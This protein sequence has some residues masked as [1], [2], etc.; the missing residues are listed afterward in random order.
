[1]SQGSEHRRIASS[2]Y[3]KCAA[4]VRRSR[5]IPAFLNA[6]LFSIAGLSAFLLRFD[7]HVPPDYR[8][9]LVIGVAIWV[10]VKSVVFARGR[11]SYTNWRH[12]SG[13]DTLAI[14]GY[15]LSGS[16]IAIP[17]IWL[18]VPPGFPRSLY[19]L[20]LIL[21]THFGLTVYV[22]ARLA[23]EHQKPRDGRK[24]E[25]IFIYGAGSS[26]ATLAREIRT[27]PELRYQVCGFL[28]DDPVKQHTM[29]QRIQVLGTGADLAK[30]ARRYSIS[31]VLIAVPSGTTDEMTR[32]L[33]HCRDAQVPCKTV[34]PISRLIGHTRL[35]SQ[36]RDVAVEDLLGRN[37][38]RLA[39][40]EIRGKI[41]GHTV[42]VTGA[43]GSI[44]SELCRQLARFQPAAIIG[45]D[46]SET[47]LF[48]VQ[49]EMRQS[50]PEVP[51]IAEIGSI[52]NPGRLRHVLDRL[53]P[54]VL[55]HAA[56]Y[57]HVPLMEASIFEAV[58][59]NV[60]GTYSVARAAAE[61]GV[62]D[63]VMI[64]SDKAVNPT[65]I[66]GATKRGAELVIR[67]MQS[68]GTKYVSVRFGNVLGS[69]GSVVP[70]FKRQ[71]AAGGPVTVTHPEMR[72]YFMTIPEAAQLVIQ[73]STMGKGG[74]IFVLDMGEQVKIVDLARRLILLSGLRPDHDIQIVFT[75]TRP[76]EKLY[77]ELNLDDEATL[78]THHPKI[79]IFRGSQPPRDLAAQLSAMRALCHARNERG[80]LN[81][82]RRLVP[83]YTPGAHLTGADPDRSHE[84]TPIGIRA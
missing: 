47:A 11:M 80:L 7:F 26:G 1:L 41:R 8:R 24:V 35:S 6:L 54:S 78:S 53:E 27:K 72:R 52:Q 57:K 66:M 21:S 79:K 67:D 58:E 16:L 34:P 49:Q 51:F 2:V 55:Y 83:D 9:H 22:F 71:I 73:A 10:A 5:L 82:L 50:F 62:R 30:L 74:E 39:E 77:E 28:D 60:L 64:S 3:R 81:A 19:L 43:A 42:M 4:P 32:M 31:Q 61:A 45:F 48:H 12:A 38:V 44:G 15:N 13:P 18:A 46:I 68:F 36:I 75:G 25:R 65:N 69:N 76:G 17:P 23:T 33:A 84:D 59:N 70:T 37:P 40:D 29:I 14:V 20:D 63:F 56:A